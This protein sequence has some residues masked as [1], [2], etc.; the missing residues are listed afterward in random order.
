MDGSLFIIDLEFISNVETESLQPFAFHGDSR[1]FDVR[2]SVP[3]ITV[4]A[5][6]GR[7]QDFH[8][9]CFHMSLPPLFLVVTSSL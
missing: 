6:P 1:G 5:S 4:S 3:V 9:F 7:I 2:I 8:V